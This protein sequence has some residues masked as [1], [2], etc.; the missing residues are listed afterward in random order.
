M[1]F[2]YFTDYE[3]QPQKIGQKARATG[4]VRGAWRETYEN[5]AEESHDPWAMMAG[6][7]T[8]RD[9]QA[10]TEPCLRLCRKY[11]VLGTLTFNII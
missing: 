11:A 3:V 5:T 7:G 10:W 1:A 6:I 4:A 2:I 8:P 9:R